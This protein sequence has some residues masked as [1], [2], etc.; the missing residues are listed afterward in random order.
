[1]LIQERTMD[2]FRTNRQVFLNDIIIAK[3]KISTKFKFSNIFSLTPYSHF[4]K[5]AINLISFVPVAME[6]K[7]RSKYKHV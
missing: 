5:M 4:I 6:G 1:M 7:I 3:T 2:F